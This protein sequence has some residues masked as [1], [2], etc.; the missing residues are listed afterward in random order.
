MKLTFAVHSIGSESLL[1]YT[2]F[3]STEL[4][5]CCFTSED[6]VVGSYVFWDD[7]YATLL[8][9]IV[10]S[11]G[12]EQCGMKLTFAVHSIGSESLL[13]YTGFA[14]TELPFCC[15]TSEDFVSPQSAIQGV[16]FLTIQVQ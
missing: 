10:I 16:L 15:F 7:N 4:P 13:N 6:F 2:G 3:A 14:S 12:P 1:N 5:F 8:D 11:S 9:S